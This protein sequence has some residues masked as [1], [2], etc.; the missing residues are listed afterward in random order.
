MTAPQTVPLDRTVIGLPIEDLDTP[1]LLLDGPAS[2]RNLAR[3]AEFFRGRKARLRP[4][5]KNHKC[6]ELARRQQ[7]AGSL[8]GFTCAKLGEAEVLAE[9][10]FADIL[11]ANQVVG[12]RKLARLAALAG[13][14][15]VM[16]AVD[17]WEQARTISEAAFAAGV[18]VGVLIEVDIGMGRCGVASGELAVQLAEKL[19]G[20][21]GLQF[22]GIQAYE[23]HAVYTNDP[24]R[25]AESVEQSMAKAVDARR[26][27]EKRGIPVDLISGGSSSTYKT[28]GRMEGVDEIQAGTYATMDWRYAQMSPEFEIALSVLARVISKRPS[29]AVL[30]VGIKGAGA[31]FGTPRIKDF[32]EAEVPSF[33]S[34]EHCVVKNAPDA[35]RVGDA[36]H[37]LPSHACSTCNLHRALY[38]HDGGRVVDVWPIEGSGRLT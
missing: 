25:R 3:M 7:E 14:I 32:P 22:R 2:Q 30:D 29:V 24:A 12:R 33:M 37:L 28:T 35:W 21:P 19:V 16:V 10:G 38:V 15:R 4:H 18:T 9:H 6:P 5:F 8:V 17:D 27:I 20:L 36:V 23:G 31:E 34:E 11:I 26:Q 1:T 13:K